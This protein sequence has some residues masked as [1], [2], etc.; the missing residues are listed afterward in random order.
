MSRG[1]GLSESATWRNWLTNDPMLTPGLRESY[2]RTLA[3]FEQFC[4]ESS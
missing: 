4:L 1:T 2:Q 3:G